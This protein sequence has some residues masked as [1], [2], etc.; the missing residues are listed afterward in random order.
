MLTKNILKTVRYLSS[1]KPLIKLTDKRSY[2][3]LYEPDYL[4]LLQPKIPIYPTID[5]QIKGYD[6]RILESY[7]SLITTISDNMELNIE[8]SWAT[9]AQSFQIQKFKQKSNIVENEYKLNVFERNIQI[10]DVPSTT[11]PT[12]LR[13]LEASLPEG[14]TLQARPHM[15]EYDEVRYVPDQELKQLKTQLDDIAQARIK[16]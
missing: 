9:P 11:F 2:S 13:L 3:K 7:Q 1:P 8:E 12:L 4:E 14:V 10:I 15:D 16:K 6:Y 5:I